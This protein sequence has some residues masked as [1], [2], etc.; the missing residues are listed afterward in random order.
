[1][2]RPGS[3]SFAARAKRRNAAIAARN[4]K[5]ID[6]NPLFHQAG[7]LDQVVTLD[8][9]HW[10]ALSVAYGE[11]EIGIKIYEDQIAWEQRSARK[12]AMYCQMLAEAI[13]AENVEEVLAD[14]DQRWPRG[15]S[16]QQWEY[17]LNYLNTYLARYT[18]RTPTAIFEEAQQRLA[19]LEEVL[20]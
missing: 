9:R 4:Q 6:A 12:Y 11:I 17:R 16:M 5:L 15:H 19:A 10:D 2:P 14:Y 8:Q 20:S 13:G 1:M 3:Q 7:V 18:K